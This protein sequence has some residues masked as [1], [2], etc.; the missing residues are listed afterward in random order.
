M[1]H[2][3]V[4][5]VLF[6]TIGVYGQFVSDVSKV[7]IAA[8]PFLEIGV[9]ARAVGMGCAFVATVDDASALFWNPSGLARLSR[10]EALLVHTEWLA[11]IRFDFAGLVL[12]LGRFGAIGGSIMTLSMDDMM[13]RTVERPEGTGEYFSAGDVALSLSYAVN[14]TD[15][16]SIGFTGKYIQ[17]SIWKESASG[18]G[19]DIGTIFTTGFYGMRI[20]A[21]LSNF[22]TD[23]SMSGKDLLVYHDIDPNKLGNNERIFAELKTDSW[24]LPLNFQ[25]G[26]AMDVLK[27]KMRR[28][29]VA[30]DAVHPSDNTESIHLGCEY[31]MQ[32]TFFLRAGYQSLFMRDS[33][34]GLT[35]GGGLWMRMLRNVQFRMDYAWADFG[36]LENVQR[37]SLGLVF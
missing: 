12:P 15:R 4:I 6:F 14:L 22:G 31:A 5:L 36:R 7:G 29:T 25:A 35:L 37:V 33:E 1:K 8:A 19:L 28:F 21:A 2:L 16:F 13:V 23:M 9:G 10:P 32:E 17:Q 18:I 27:G 3:L 34:E 24:P 30:A 20:G 26:V 11:D